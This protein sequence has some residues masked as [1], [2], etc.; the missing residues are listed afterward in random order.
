MHL[1][2]TNL[3]YHHKTPEELCL[4]VEQIGNRKHKQI[5]QNI[6]KQFDKAQIQRMYIQTSLHI[7]FRIHQCFLD[8]QQKHNT[9]QGSLRK[10][11]YKRESVRLY[12]QMVLEIKTLVALYFLIQALIHTFYCD[13]LQHPYFRKLE[14]PSTLQEILKKLQ[15]PAQTNAIQIPMSSRIP[16]QQALHNTFSQNTEAYQPQELNFDQ[17]KIVL[18]NVFD[19]IKRTKRFL[20][21]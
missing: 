21:L 4:L 19:Y 17:Y 8:Y 6:R 14:F 5:L 9:A 11:H 3:Q 13:T 20:L 16:S 7:I 12:R 1:V 15:T 18:K 2:G 10:V